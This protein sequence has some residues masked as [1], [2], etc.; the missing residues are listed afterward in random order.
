LVSTRRGVQP[1][2]GN[3]DSDRSFRRRRHPAENAGAA[4][5]LRPRICHGPAAGLPDS[6]VG[7]FT[8]ALCDEAGKNGRKIIS[9]KIISM[10][11]DWRR[12]FAF[13]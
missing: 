12:I 11:R 8:P 1:R 5:R 10:N 9:M 4:R 7:T 3:H 2:G 6:K 13:E